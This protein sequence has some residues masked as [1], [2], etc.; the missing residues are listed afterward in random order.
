M[1]EISETQ[2]ISS[3]TDGG[4]HGNIKLFPI[5]VQYNDASQW[6]IA[7]TIAVSI[8]HVLQ[9]HNLQFQWF[10]PLLGVLLQRRF[11]LRDELIFIETMAE[12]T[13]L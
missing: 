13:K 2:I 12:T 5:F 4:N 6:V 11:V 1:K 7:C 9:E 8:E 10:L 3:S